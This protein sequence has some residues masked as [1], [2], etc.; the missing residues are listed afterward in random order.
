[1]TTTWHADRELLQAYV[2]DEL[3]DAHAS[4]VEAHVLACVQ[5]RQALAPEVASDRLDAIW[6]DTVDVLDR[7][8]TRPVE[9][10]LRLLRVAPGNARLLA[11]TPSLQLSWLAAIAVAAGFGALASHASE[12]GLAFFLV[13]APLVPV[14]GVAAAYGPGVDPA[15]ELT[16][17]APMSGFRLVLLRAAAV[18]AASVVLTG[19]ASFGLVAL[20]WTAAAWVLPALALTGA[21][22]ALTLVLSPERAGT[23]VAVAWLSAVLIGWAATGDDLGAFHTVG[24]LCCAVVAAAAAVVIAR[25][26]ELFEIGSQR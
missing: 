7:P 10:L 3:D 2:R 19:V 17:A 1:M 12:N 26:N 14:V 5:C 11:A 15:H 13:I 6:Q 8:R 23:C 9:R 16:V 25:R 18:L 4:S 24:Q 20:D 22:L 21:T